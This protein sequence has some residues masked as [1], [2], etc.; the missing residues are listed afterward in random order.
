MIDADKKNDL[1]S[2]DRKLD[3]HLVLLMQQKI[4]SQD[5]L[6]PPQ[7]LRKE[8]ETLRQVLIFLISKLQIKWKIFRPLNEL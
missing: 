3:R 1:K 2:L 6:L 5:F 7:S 8:G 4:G